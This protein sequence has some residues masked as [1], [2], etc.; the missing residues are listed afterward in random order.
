MDAIQRL[1]F[2][3]S[4]SILSLSYLSLLFCSLFPSLH[5]LLPL[6]DNS[7]SLLTPKLA[8]LRIDPGLMEDKQRQAKATPLSAPRQKGYTEQT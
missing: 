4:A 3:P 8:V 2:S 5:S 7:D 1:I 6:S